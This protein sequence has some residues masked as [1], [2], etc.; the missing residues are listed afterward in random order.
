MKIARNCLLFAVAIILVAPSVCHAE[1]F[2]FPNLLPSFG[3]KKTKRKPAVKRMSY[4]AGT[5]ARPAKRPA[6]KKSMFSLP[7]LPAMHLPPLPK[8]QVP[9]AIKRMNAS[10]KHFFSKTA[11]MLSP[12]KMTK[13]HFPGFGSSPKRNKKQG[14]ILTSWWAPYAPAPKRKPKTPQEWM[15]QK[16]VPF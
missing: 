12:R 6:A 2:S 4:D 5:L 14:N 9:Q 8:P 3:A 1:G 10:T 11:S 16:R 15:S 13:P 7:R